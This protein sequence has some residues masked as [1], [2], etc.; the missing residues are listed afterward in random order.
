MASDEQ[1]AIDAALQVT[2]YATYEGA[3]HR[4]ASILSRRSSQ[5]RDEMTT[6]ARQAAALTIEVHRSEDRC[7]TARS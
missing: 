7:Q 5:L 1:E 6:F 3:A 2:D 4:Q